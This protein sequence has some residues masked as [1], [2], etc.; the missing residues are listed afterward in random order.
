[1]GSR[2]ELFEQIRLDREQGGPLSE[3]RELLDVVRE[4]PNSYRPGSAMS[5]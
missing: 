2:V 1:M 4:A 3:E 5:S